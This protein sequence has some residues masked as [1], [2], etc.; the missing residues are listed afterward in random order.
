MSTVAGSQALYWD[1]G[2]DERRFRI[3]AATVLVVIL[4][5][6]FIVPLIDM[7]APVVRFMDEVSPRFAQLLQERTQPLP[8]PPPPPEETPREAI[9]EQPLPEPAASEPVPAAPKPVEPPPVSP[10]RERASRSGLL[11]L[12]Q[13][14]AQL[15]DDSPLRALEN[16]EL[17]AAQ[18]SA[19]TQDVQAVISSRAGTASGGVNAPSA[20]GDTTRLAEHEVTRVDAPTVVRDSDLA[21]AG[22]VL[23]A[24]FSEEIQRVFDENRAAL[25]TLYKRALRSNP[26]LRG[27]VV[28]RLTILPSGAVAE[29]EIVSSELGDAELERRLVARVRQFDFGAREVAVT[30]TTYPIDFFPG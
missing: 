27:T 12:S 6:G 5:L 8:P 28:L 2:P 24:R 23:P 18:S 19:P 4:V 25:N 16:Q 26:S 14:I 9:P 30:T 15:R 3:I 22:P 13:E 7:P 17:R 10:A 1:E 21:G 11:A 29:C 20:Q